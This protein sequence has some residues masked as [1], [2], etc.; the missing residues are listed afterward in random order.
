[1]EV[2]QIIADNPGPSARLDR[3]ILV[4]GEMTINI[5]EHARSGGKQW[6]V[7]AGQRPYRSTG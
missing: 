1:M 5:P 6:V 3:G 2:R 7:Q 4:V